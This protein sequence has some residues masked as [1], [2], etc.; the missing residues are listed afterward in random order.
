MPYA[1]FPKLKN[2]AVK[3]SDTCEYVG[4]RSVACDCKGSKNLRNVCN[5]VNEHF[6]K[7]QVTIYLIALRD[8]IR[9]L[10]NHP[11]GGKK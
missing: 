10:G 6:N 2:L 1:I 7:A 3:K 4:Y 8:R 9:H 11:S 5:Y